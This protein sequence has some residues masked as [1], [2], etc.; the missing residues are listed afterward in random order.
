MR[1]SGTNA[2]SAAYG[3]KLG[4]FNLSGGGTSYVEEVNGRLLRHLNAYMEVGFSITK[5]F[6]CQFV[7]L[8]TI[9]DDNGEN[10]VLCGVRLSINQSRNEQPERTKQEE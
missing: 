3:L 2:V 10:L 6:R 1:L 5:T 7:H 4:R 8:S 9:G